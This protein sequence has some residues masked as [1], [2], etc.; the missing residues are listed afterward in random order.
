MFIS[1]KPIHKIK[2]RYYTRQILLYI[3]VAGALVISGPSPYFAFAFWKKA[4]QIKKQSKKT[5]GDLFRYLL[6]KR[7]IE[8]TRE[9]HDIRIALT[10]KGKQCAGKYQIDELHLPEPPKKWDRKYRIVIFDIPNASNFIRNVFRRKLKEFG[11]YPLQKSV[12]VYPFPCKEEVR[13]LREFLGC[14]KDQIRYVE[15]TT[16][17]DDELIRRKFSI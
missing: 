9:G 10:E 7:M 4:L 16:L 1:M 2:T 17:E 6:G 3:L 14:S 11:F 13:F 5:H 12:W 15:T 8:W